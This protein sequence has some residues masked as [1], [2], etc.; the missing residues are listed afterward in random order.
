MT[1]KLLSVPAIIV[2]I[3]AALLVMYAPSVKIDIKEPRSTRQPC[4]QMTPRQ[5]NTILEV[6]KRLVKG[7]DLDGYPIMADK[8]TRFSFLA[9]RGFVD[10]NAMAQFQ[11]YA[12]Y[13]H[14]TVN[15]IGR[16]ECWDVE[17]KGVYTILD[18]LKELW[19]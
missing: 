18:A 2:I 16:G 3:L 13:I 8:A 19:K 12:A 1:A 9:A 15:E 14:Q 11:M 4:N 10:Q 6:G 5:E 7:G 17:D